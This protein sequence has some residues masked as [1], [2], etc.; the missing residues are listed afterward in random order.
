MEGIRVVLFQGDTSTDAS[1]TNVLVMMRQF[2]DAPEGGESEETGSPSLGCS[3][4]SVVES[5]ATSEPPPVLESAPTCAPVQTLNGD[6]NSSSN[7]KKASVSTKQV[8]WTA[9]RLHHRAREAQ[10]AVHQHCVFALSCS[11]CGQK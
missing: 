10:E 11:F 3:Q 5:V 9:H 1:P 2:R 4:D 7:N 6:L 8:T